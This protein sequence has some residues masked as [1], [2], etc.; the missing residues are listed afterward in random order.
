M[1]ARICTLRHSQF[2]AAQPHRGTRKHTNKQ[3]DS[4]HGAKPKRFSEAFTI[5]DSGGVSVLSADAASESGYTTSPFRKT[6]SKGGQFLA[7]PLP[8]ALFNLHDTP[9][10][11]SPAR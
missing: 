3:Q 2:I 11:P 5:R 4:K 10:F 6:V 7:R 1:Q 9:H 8:F